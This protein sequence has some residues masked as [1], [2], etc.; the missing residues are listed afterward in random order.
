MKDISNTVKAAQ[1]MI[2]FRRRD[3]F[4]K[5]LPMIKKNKHRVTTRKIELTEE[6]CINL[7]VGMMVNI[8][9]NI[10]T[11]GRVLSI[12]YYQNIINYFNDLI[13]WVEKDNLWIASWCEIYDFDELKTKEALIDKIKKRLKDYEN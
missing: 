1:R 3:K 4:G 9:H 13:K 2:K 6:G 11:P 7:V 12:P 5:F 8:C 10:E